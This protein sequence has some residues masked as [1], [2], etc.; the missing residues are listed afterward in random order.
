MTAKIEVLREPRQVSPWIVIGAAAALIAGL[1]VITVSEPEVTPVARPPVAESIART[2][3]VTEMAALK[4]ANATRYLA[5][6]FWTG[7][8]SSSASED[9]IEAAVK[10]RLA[11]GYLEAQAGG[12]GS[13]S[14]PRKGH[15]VRRSG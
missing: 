8:V 13:G 14:E 11:H 2:D 1:A 4:S 5:E 12:N 9:A 3:D 7:T 10:A 15:P 6:H